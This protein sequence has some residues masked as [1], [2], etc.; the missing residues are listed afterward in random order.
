MQK[1]TDIEVLSTTWQKI[2]RHAEE[3]IDYFRKQND[4]DKDPLETAKLRG[5]V[6][7]YKELLDLA[8]PAITGIDLTAVARREGQ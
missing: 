6:A 3:R 4:G 2:S 7:A 8:G 5:K 1:L